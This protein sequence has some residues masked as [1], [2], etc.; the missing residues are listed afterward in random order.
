LS[1][2]LH[3]NLSRFYFVYYFFVGVFVPY[4]ALYLQSE[5]FSPVEIGILMSIFQ[6]SRIFAPNFWGWLADHTAKRTVWIRLNTVLGVLGFIAVFWAEGFWSMLLVMGALSLFTSST[7]PLSESLTLA[8]LANTKGH[9]SRIRMWG[10]VGFIVASVL[11]GYLIDFSGIS[12]LLWAILVVQVT[13]FLL[14]F[15]LTEVNVAPHH[16]DHFSVWNILRN[17]AVV[18]LLIGCALMVSAHGVLYNFY[19]IYLSA[20]GYSK[21]MIG[22]LWSLG[23]IC[24]IV[25]FMLMPIIMR[26][27]SLKAIILASLA[28]AVIRF[29]MIGLAVDCLI[30]L[31]IAQSL[32]AAT[33]GSFHAATV[34]VVAKFFNGRHQAKGQAIYNSVTYGLGGAIGGIAGGYALQGL[35]GE[36]TFLLAAIF[37]LIGFA[38]IAFGMKLAETHGD[39]G[40]FS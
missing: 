16:T 2:S 10:S 6:I 20:H 35:G 24:E 9:Y 22:W 38:V 19:S 1:H 40:M 21:G 3:K 23:V 14:T 12:S 4:W 11:L 26:R 31:L 30:L 37:P 34:E 32:H 18:A 29:T 36:L 28:L 13:L 7:M 15:T 27:F 5:H 25:V 17:P 8:H 33:F 39:A